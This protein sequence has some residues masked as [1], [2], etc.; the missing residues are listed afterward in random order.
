[1]RY[2]Y[3]GTRGASI[4]QSGPKFRRRVL[5]LGAFLFLLSLLNI[6]FCSYYS[7]IGT[8]CTNTALSDGQQLPFSITNYIYNVLPGPLGG[9]TGLGIKTCAFTE[10]NY[11]Y[12]SFPMEGPK[13]IDH[14]NYTTT[15]LPASPTATWQACMVESNNAAGKMV[16]SFPTSMAF[17][18]QQTLVYTWLAFAILYRSLCHYEWLLSTIAFMCYAVLGVVAYYSFNPYLPYP[19]QTAATVASLTYYIQPD[20]YDDS[21]LTYTPSYGTKQ[22]MA[23]SDP[24]KI[25]MDDDECQKAYHFN[26]AFLVIQYMSVAIVVMLLIIAFSAEAIR[27]RYPLTNQ[28]PPLKGTFVPCAICVICLIGYAVMVFAKASASILSLDIMKAKD[29]PASVFPFAQGSVDIATIFLIVTTMSVIRGA[30][31]SSTSA[32]RLSAV[33]AVLHVALVYPSIIGNYEVTNY[34]DMWKMGEDPVDLNTV[35]LDDPHTAFFGSGC[36]GFWN[37]YFL[38][39]YNTAADVDAAAVQ[40]DDWV[41]P[42]N[43]QASDMCWYTWIS[44]VAQSTIFVMMHFQIIACG[45]VYKSNKGRPT[46]VFDPQPPTAP[47]ADPRE[48]PLLGNETNVTVIGRI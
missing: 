41:H 45:M 13:T 11:N 7:Y 35:S 24:V 42:S 47:G 6:G 26:L 48:E 21:F 5:G 14:G 44:F 15:Q 20:M 36:K 27:R 22:T 40:A 30:T 34:N 37:T 1:M 12:S 2:T 9:A 23:P 32:F 3:D 18:G 39:Y 10:L 31:R 25:M 4:E 17:T 8:A 28:L 16:S 33:T 38:S 19:H 43:D 29:Q 46:D